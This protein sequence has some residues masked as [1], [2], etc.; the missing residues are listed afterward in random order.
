MNDLSGAGVAT[1]GRWLCA[2]VPVSVP[3]VLAPLLLLGTAV[4]LFILVVVGNALFLAAL[5][6]LSTFIISVFLWNSL[7]FRRNLALLL[8]VDR[9]P[10]SDLLSAS[11]G[12]LVKITGVIPPVQLSLFFIFL[13]N[14]L[15]IRVPVQVFERHR[16]FQL[17]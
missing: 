13:D 17:S 4:S 16:Q 5:L 10:V 12:Q 2:T 7:S 3:F 15:W 14:V 9:M 11:D 1:S 8:F 6:L